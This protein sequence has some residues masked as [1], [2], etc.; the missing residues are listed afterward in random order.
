MVFEVARFLCGLEEDKAATNVATGACGQALESLG[1]FFRQER[2]RCFQQ[3]VKVV[4]VLQ[5]RVMVLDRRDPSPTW[6]W[7]R[8]VMK[9]LSGGAAY[10]QLRLRL[11]LLRL[12]SNVLGADI[13]CGEEA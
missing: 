10:L 12:C 9:R 13:R 11:I 7:I 6:M 4:F 2:G 8:A 1:A 5:V 3:F